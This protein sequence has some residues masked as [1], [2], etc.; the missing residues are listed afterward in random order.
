MHGTA[1][2]IAG[3]NLANPTALI[4][5]GAHD[6]RPHRETEAAT[7]VREAVTA[8]LRDGQKLTHDLG[9]HAGTTEIAEAI[10]A[11][12]FSCTRRILRSR[13]RRASRCR[14]ARARPSSRP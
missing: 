11:K 8:V 3:K 14:R 2:D 7:R 4:L 6:A 13:A 5:S 9:G 10:T 1:P 12:I